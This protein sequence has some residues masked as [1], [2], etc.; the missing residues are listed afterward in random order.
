MGTSTGRLL[1]VDFAGK[2]RLFAIGPDSPV[3]VTTHGTAWTV[4]AS[5]KQGK[6]YLDFS[7]AGEL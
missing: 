2:E 4:M 5:D 7:T 3:F 1:L 6:L